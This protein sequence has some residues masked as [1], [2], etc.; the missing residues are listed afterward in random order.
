MERT[1]PT[2]LYAF[3]FAIIAGVLIALGHIVAGLVLA[4]LAVLCL[5]AWRNRDE[6]ERGIY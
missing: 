4:V 3:G 6:D 1:S 2:G 5:W